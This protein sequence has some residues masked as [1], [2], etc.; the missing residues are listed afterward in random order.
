MR[1][2]RDSPVSWT[3]RAGPKLAQIARPYVDF[4]NAPLERR[5]RME[6]RIADTF[7]DSLTRLTSDHTPGVA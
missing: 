7:T 5:H 3:I 4:I 1:A 6:F 2:T